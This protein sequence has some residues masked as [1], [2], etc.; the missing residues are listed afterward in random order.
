MT[1]AK[2]G[3]SFTE[4][5][6]RHTVDTYMRDFDLLVVHHTRVAALH[7]AAKRTSGK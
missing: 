5:K 4:W 1:P 7:A 6:P 3:K 2:D